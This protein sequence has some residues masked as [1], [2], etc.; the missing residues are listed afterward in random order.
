MEKF[1]VTE[2]SNYI[3]WDYFY[4][5]SYLASGKDSMPVIWVG[6]IEDFETIYKSL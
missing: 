5:Y 6:K 1:S 2:S 4:P 3:V